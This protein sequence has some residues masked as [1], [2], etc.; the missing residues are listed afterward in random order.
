MRTK[1]KW[2]VLDMPNSIKNEFLIPNAPSIKTPKTILH[3]VVYKQHWLTPNFISATLSQSDRVVQ[4]LLMLCGTLFLVL[5]RQC[6]CRQ[7][8]FN[9]RRLLKYAHGVDT[10]KYLE[11]FNWNDSC[12]AFPQAES[13]CATPLP[14]YKFY[15]ASS[16]S[17]SASVWLSL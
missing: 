17:T 9:V 5:L 7:N 8:R 6:H 16:N 12:P 10:W 1:L 11:D 15:V 4:L 14:F 2:W 13:L 3:Y